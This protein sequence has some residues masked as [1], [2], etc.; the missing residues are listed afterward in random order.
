MVYT[1]ARRRN[2]NPSA[3]FSRGAG[4]QISCRIGHG[5]PSRRTDGVLC[6]GGA[7]RSVAI[8]GKGR[9]LK[10]QEQHKEEIHLADMPHR[11][12]RHNIRLPSGGEKKRQFFFRR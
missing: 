7:S 11:F 9:G 5:P 8:P 2:G 3:G 10:D 6:Y 1:M 12:V 4:Y